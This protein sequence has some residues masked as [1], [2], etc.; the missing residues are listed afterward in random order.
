MA[1]ELIQ[2]ILPWGDCTLLIHPVYPYLAATPDILVSE[3]VVVKV[4]WLF[5]GRNEMIEP[6]T[7][8]PVLETHAKSN[9]TALKDATV[10][11]YFG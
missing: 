5:T 11:I 8:F 10:I 2:K 6:G 9:V 7:I 3:D 4:K 1:L